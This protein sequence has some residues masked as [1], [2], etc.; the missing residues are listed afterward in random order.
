MPISTGQIIF[1]DKTNW[2]TSQKSVPI[3]ITD[4]QGKQLFRAQVNI[5]HPT[6]EPTKKLVGLSRPGF[7]PLPPGEEKE[8][9]K[10][11]ANMFNTLADE[12]KA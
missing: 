11:V 10:A 4:A 1:K 5:F 12:F 9:L 8:V 6:G 7:V 2:T 3:I